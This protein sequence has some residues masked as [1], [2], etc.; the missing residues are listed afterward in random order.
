LQWLPPIY[1]ST[2]V[3]AVNTLVCLTTPAK[4]QIVSQ[5]IMI[6]P[7]SIAENVP[8]NIPRG[9]NQSSYVFLEYSAIFEWQNYLRIR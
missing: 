6:C 4:F 8:P 5:N 1:L 9:N 3:S 7:V 2:D